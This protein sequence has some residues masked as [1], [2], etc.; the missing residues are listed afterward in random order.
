MNHLS[1]AIILFLVGFLIIYMIKP[2]IIY[3]RDGSLRQFGVGYR[4]KT[5]FPMWLIVF[6]L[7]IFCYH[8]AFY[9]QHKLNVL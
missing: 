3:N 2:T 7:A 8:G 1:I 5:V 4:K 9:V 6:I